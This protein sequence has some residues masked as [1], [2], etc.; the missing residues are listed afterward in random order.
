MQR[1]VFLLCACAGVA[2]AASAPPKGPDAKEAAPV[3]MSRTGG[4]KTWANI[5]ELQA[6]ANAGNP[7]AQEQLGERLL[8]GEDIAQ[9][10]PAGRALLEKAARAGEPTAAFRVAMILD[11]GDGVPQDRLRA[12]DYFKSAAAGGVNEAF[13]NV[14]AA[15]VSAR[16]VKRDY[17][18]GLAWLIL[19]TKHGAPP[20]GEK[21]VRARLEKLGHAPWI[22]AAEKRAP[23][24]ERELAAKK[25][26][27]FL[28]PPAPFALAP[29][30]GK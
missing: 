14:G 8:R 3:L 20:E 17:V 22:A 30:A 16:G 25:S 1:F 27:D 6:A 9:D 28:P 29:A 15:Y 12:L 11:D 21:T 19:S 4:G 26:A 5:K 10:K 2:G 7:R 13:Y 18:E 24:L 23:E